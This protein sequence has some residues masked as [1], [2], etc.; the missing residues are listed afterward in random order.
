M[1]IYGQ[2]HIAMAKDV[3]AGLAFVESVD[4]EWRGP[5]RTCVSVRVGDGLAQGGRVYPVASTN[6]RVWYLTLPAGGIA[7]R[8][9]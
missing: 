2:G 3:G 1:D 5:G 4:H 9:A 6:D 7:V 8:E